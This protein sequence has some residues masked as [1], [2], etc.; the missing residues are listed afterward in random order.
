MSGA[1]IGVLVGG[2]LICAFAAAIRLSEAT[3]D[4]RARIAEWFEDNVHWFALVG[5]FACC[6]PYWLVLDDSLK[7]ALTD[8][9]V[10]DVAECAGDRR[11]DY[12]L[13]GVTADGVRCRKLGHRPWPGVSRSVGGRCS[14]RAGSML[15]ALRLLYLMFVRLLGWLP[16]LENPGWVCRARTRAGCLTW[17]STL[18]GHVPCGCP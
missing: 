18:G 4:I 17:A 11:S 1:L 3:E 8:D 2:A 10:G 16:L 7:G 12:V 5:F 13:R 14:R 15:V 6:R 9:C